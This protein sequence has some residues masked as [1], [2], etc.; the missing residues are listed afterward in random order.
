MRLRLGAALGLLFFAVSLL[1][2]TD[3]RHFIM[4]GD[5]FFPVDQLLVLSKISHTWSADQLGSVSYAASGVPVRAIFALLQLIGVSAV[6]IQR[7]FL[8]FFYGLSAFAMCELAKEFWDGEAWPVVAAVWYPFGIF[9]CQSI[10][11]EN[12]VVALAVVPLLAYL[13]LR[14]F[15]NILFAP[16]FVVTTLSLG[17]IASNPPSLVLSVTLMATLTIVALARRK[18]DRRRALYVVLLLTVGSVL[19]NLWWLNTTRIAIAANKIV[20]S[21]VADWSWVLRRSDLSSIVQ[22]T[23][24]WGFGYASDPW[25][26]IGRSFL[27]NPFAH[28]ALY[29]TPILAIIGIPALRRVVNLQRAMLLLGVCVV[30]VVLAKGTHA[31]ISG[32]NAFLYDHVPLM[33]LYREPV[34]FL[35]VLATAFPLLAA[36]SLPAIIRRIRYPVARYAAIAMFFAVPVVTGYPLWSGWEF[37]FVPSQQMRVAIPNYWHDASAFIN[38]ANVA[39]ERVLL[40]P[41]DGFYQTSYRWGFDGVDRIAET[42]L[43]APVLRLTI[44]RNGYLANPYADGAQKQLEEAIASQ[45]GDWLATEFQRLGIGY[46][47]VRGDVVSDGRIT[48]AAEIHEALRR[49]KTRFERSFGPLELYSFTVGPPAYQPRWILRSCISPQDELEAA[50][51]LPPTVAIIR[52][53]EPH[54]RRNA[55]FLQTIASGGTVLPA[56][57]MLLHHKRE[58]DVARLALPGQMY[59]AASRLIDASDEVTGIA[60]GQT[61]AHVAFDGPWHAEGSKAYVRCVGFENTDDIIV[62][63]VITGTPHSMY[64]AWRPGASN[65]CEASASYP[66]YS[67]LY[68]SFGQRH[69]T[70]LRVPG[71]VRWLVLQL[72]TSKLQQPNLGRVLRLSTVR[73]TGLGTNEAEP[74]RSVVLF[75]MNLPLRLQPSIYGVAWPAE[76]IFRLPN[77]SLVSGYVDRNGASPPALNARSIYERVVQR[78]PESRSLQRLD[79]TRVDVLGVIPRSEP[80]PEAHV[81]VVYATSYN[82]WD[83]RVLAAARFVKPVSGEALYSGRPLIQSPSKLSV[84]TGPWWN[85]IDIVGTTHGWIGMRQAYDPNWHMTGASTEAVMD[86][87]SHAWFL[88]AINNYRGAGLP[89]GDQQR[90]LVIL[91]A[92]SFGVMILLVRMLRLRHSW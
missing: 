25:L 75:K 87:Y 78:D 4:G 55:N 38:A 20:A 60:A 69:I 84:T 37:G 92:I 76:V 11:N 33:F 27:T 50:M 65:P 30:A 61:A 2:W 51:R 24:F 10:P 28:G 7:L 46:I 31:P 13:A 47:V 19:M 81:S 1:T 5:I 36:A 6:G 80:L 59:V 34:K 43:Y 49:A 40:L 48:S 12:N 79:S 64:A 56:G 15:A 90:I 18:L 68:R 72:R 35:V 41:E 52:S 8:A 62:H 22:Q 39:H 66:D 32:F 23:S 42:S 83:V 70:P 74:A 88:P 17:L 44:D 54:C 67:L 16:V 53:D 85:K 14:T 73:V 29:A 77:G 89:L 86:G 82:Y 21:G 58:R 71:G 63:D 26:T 45:R 3:S 9:Y 57:T 91:A